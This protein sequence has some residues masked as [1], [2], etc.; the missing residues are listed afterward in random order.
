MAWYAL[1]HI[2][3]AIEET[4][5]F[6]LPFDPWRWAKLAVIVAVVSG[7]GLPGGDTL[8]T[9][10][11]GTDTGQQD[12]PQLEEMPEPRSSLT[13]ATAAM[14]GVA[15]STYYAAAAVIALLVAGYALL[16][17][18][19]V[20][21]FY[22]SLLTGDVRIRAAARR[23]GW[24]GA[25]LFGFEAVLVLLGGG[26]LVGAGAYLLGV[27]E[28]GTFMPLLHGGM[29]LLLAA[30]F[31]VL[32]VVLHLTNRFIPLTMLQHDVSVLQAWQLLYPELRREWQQVAVYLVVNL[33]L[34]VAVGV[35]VGVLSLLLLVLPGIPI[36]V[37]AMVTGL[38]STPTVAALLI[39]GLFWI[40]AKLY[41]FRVPAET[42]LWTYT[43][44]VYQD[45]TG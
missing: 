8:G 15:D 38:Y 16:R 12:V 24:Y 19:F 20:F 34:T 21:V 5:A 10:G 25:R 35:A 4:K 13:A 1:E 23:Y 27:V 26:L 31:A 30:V 7:I 29:L 22:R 40:A 3:G 41:V 45:L 39:G 18:V 11:D 17:T 43:V 28:T 32:V 37:L 44:L 33:F 36:A 42:Y 2:T 14:P 6:L 9:V